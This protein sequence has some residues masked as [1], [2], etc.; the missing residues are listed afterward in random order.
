MGYV[1]QITDLVLVRDDGF[2]IM[3]QLMKPSTE[4]QSCAQR[5]VGSISE[6]V[7]V[8]VVAKSVDGVSV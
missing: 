3:L 4:A 1:V 2:K 7:R 6:N 8:F 5:K